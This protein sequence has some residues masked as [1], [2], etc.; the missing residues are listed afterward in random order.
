MK[1]W[2]WAGITLAALVWTLYNAARIWAAFQLAPGAVTIN[3][4]WDTP[5]GRL[6]LIGLGVFLT[7]LA[8]WVRSRK[9]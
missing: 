7:A 3:V 1:R 2:L 5:T 8:F 6:M 9:V 4:L